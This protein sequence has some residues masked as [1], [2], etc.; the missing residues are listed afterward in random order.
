MYYTNEYIYTNSSLSIWEL[1]APCSIVCMQ[2]LR[3]S[4]VFHYYILFYQSPPPVWYQGHQVQ[5]GLVA[6]RQAGLEWWRKTGAWRQ[7]DRGRKVTTPLDADW[8][9]HLRSFPPAYNGLNKNRAISILACSDGLYV[10]MYVLRGH[11]VQVDLCIRCTEQTESSFFRLE[12]AVHYM[13]TL[14]VTFF[15]FWQPRSSCLSLNRAL[16]CSSFRLFCWCFSAA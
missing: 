6:G 10:H 2:T 15:S 13:K 14:G 12:A 11:Y 4:T 9:L 8:A 16:D 5:S 7:R 3:S 1:F